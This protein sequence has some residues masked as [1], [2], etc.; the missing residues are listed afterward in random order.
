MSSQKPKQSPRPRKRA[1]A[2][3][4]FWPVRLIAAARCRL[5]HRNL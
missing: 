5:P 3:R 4:G 1:A 2:F